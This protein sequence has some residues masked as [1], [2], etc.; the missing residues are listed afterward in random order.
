M[1]NKL[2]KKG[3]SK[4]HK[5]CN[6]FNLP[7]SVCGLDCKKCYARKAE[8]RFPAVLEARNRNLEAAESDSFIVDMVIEIERSSNKMFR[9]HESGDFY[10]QPYIDKWINIVSICDW[11][12]FYAY[13]KKKDAFDFTGLE[14]CR[15]MNL[16]NSM[17]PLGLNYG[18][19]EYCDELVTKYNY[20]LCPCRKGVHIE[21]MNECNICLRAKKVCFVE[22]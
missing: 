1:Y 10:S 20:I 11:V 16:I 13:T 12:Q 21:C 15:N 5:S 9:I 17:T 6:V 2:I 19:I 8:K 14:Y 7:T 22:H 3:N 4:I 18:P